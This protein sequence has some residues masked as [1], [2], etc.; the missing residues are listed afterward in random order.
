[1]HQRNLEGINAARFYA[2]LSIALFHMAVLA[3]LDLPPCLIFIRNYGA[4]GV[5]LFYILSAF[6][7]SY[8]YMGKLG[9]TES[10]WHF[11]AR[12]FFRIAPLYY[13]L[14]I[15]YPT[16]LWL[17]YG[18]LF[19][20]LRFVSAI[21]FT[22]NALPY[23]TD[24]IV[25]AS[26]SIG[27]EMLFYAIFPLIL[28]FATS[29]LR[30]GILFCGSMLVA[31]I[32]L[33]LFDSQVMKHFASN[34]LLA[35]FRYFSAGILAYFVWRDIA[36]TPL[37]HRICISMACG[38]FVMLILYAGSIINFIAGFGLSYGGAVYAFKELWIFALS[39]LVI[40]LAFSRFKSPIL[41]ATGKMGEASFSMYLWH[42]IIIA[43]LIRGSVYK[44]I[45]ESVSNPF[46]VFLASTAITFAVLFPVAW[47]SFHFIEK[48]LGVAL[49][50]IATSS[51]LF[52]RRPA[53]AG[54]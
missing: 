1:M 33:H 52:Q 20:P 10:V 44:G 26:W 39:L 4:F 25:P 27:V 29:G 51:R 5:P 54:S 14:L 32:W 42:P 34:S 13:V 40:G 15:I 18:M 7:L 38:S 35:N 43:L 12:R 28:M 50:N 49:R 11:W 23:Q 45:M 53:Y 21:T 9:S 19:S 22:F 46:A 30:S 17:S 48:R 2:A 41:A 36:W 47:A 16:Y 6:A 3:K 31:A 8:G 37:R 24:G